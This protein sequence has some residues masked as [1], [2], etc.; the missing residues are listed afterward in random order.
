MCSLFDYIAII[1]DYNSVCVPSRA[2]SMRH[3]QGRLVFSQTL[4]FRQNVFF[5]FCVNSGEAIVED[6]YWRVAD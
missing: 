3:E 1:H 4:E 2:D 5:G 6:E